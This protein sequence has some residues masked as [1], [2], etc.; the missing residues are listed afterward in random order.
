M[1]STGQRQRQSLTPHFNTPNF[2]DSPSTSITPTTKSWV[3]ALTDLP[4]PLEKKKIINSPKNSKLYQQLFHVRKLLKNK[5]STIA[6]LKKQRVANKNKIISNTHK[7]FNKV[8]FSSKNSRYLV[9]MQILHKKRKPWSENEKK[10][11]MSI[12]YKS[13]STYKHMR[14]IGI[15]LP[16][17]STI[18]R[19]L[20][21]IDYLPG[22][23]GEYIR[24]IKLKVSTMSYTDKKC[25]ILL[26]EMAISK[27]I[28]YN[29]T[30]DLIEGF[31]DLG[32][33]GR[34]SKFAKHA[35]MVMVRGLYNNWKF[36]LC[37]F[38][39]NNGVKGDDLLILIKDCVDNIL[40]VGLL[41]L[42]IVCDQGAQNRKLFS[43]LNGTES[44]P[45]TEIHDQKL[46]LIYDIPHLIKSIRN[47]LLTGDIQL[48]KILITFEDIKKTYKINVCSETAR[49]MCK[50]SP[51]HLNP[52]PFQ[53]MSCKLAL[54]I[55]SNST[56]AAI[57]TCIH[58]GEL[59][60]KTAMDTANFVLEINNTFDACNS[61]NLYD[62]NLNKRPMN[63]N[64]THIFH[65][66]RKT[67]STFQNAKKISHKNKKQSVPP[68]FTG[69]IWSL[70]AII[71]L[72]E[73]EQ[74]DIST[75]TEQD[76]N[77]YFL[78]TNRLNQD[79]LENMFSIIRQK[80]GYTR[81][82][83][84]K[85][86]RSCFA[87][88]CSFSLMK[89]SEKC[90]CEVDEDNFLT[91]DVLGESEVVKNACQSEMNT[92]NLTE[93]NNEVLDK[94][95]QS[96]D[97]SNENCSESE[98]EN[99]KLNVTLEECSISYFAGYLAKRCIDNFQCEN[100]K[101]VLVNNE[102]YNNSNEILIMY[103]T[104]EQIDFF[105]NEGLKKPSTWLIKICK[106]SLNIFKTTFKTIISE[107]RIMTK[108]FDLILIKLN[109]KNIDF[110]ESPCKEHYLYII[111]LLLVI[112]IYKA[113]KWMAAEE[114]VTKPQFNQKHPKLRI[115]Q[116]S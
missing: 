5:R 27:C 80:N 90:N 53:K 1:Y 85:M 74:E 30:I 28:E 100:C 106:I 114:N 101:Q 40:N 76:P 21:S 46:V 54:Q 11:A 24:Q 96:V 42:A 32:S 49:A 7:F 10:I 87:S 9:S 77:K 59:Q 23:V 43:L 93:D 67:I 108:M 25:V 105:G 86:I 17:D 91:L 78:L 41:P 56:S 52:N 99:D 36:P 83:S 63:V 71:S 50:I 81:N 44:N 33:L 12:Y 94:S 16:G 26:D 3:S 39:S 29:K 20:K 79:P 14:K 98:L 35:L 95:F 65:Q 82:P 51:I 70:T 69:I 48:N 110:N 37:Y 18:R 89:A 84:A 111:K 13:P 8:K 31:Q 64:N 6:K 115:L 2:N 68:C 22:F 88:I 34:S 92:T 62:V 72:Y 109:K 103:K 19:W 57:K 15:V 73:S 61:K 60:S 75:N 55:F 107:P 102:I 97:N 4:S 66:L 112:R 113:C 47:N 58:T 104:F 45:I 38:L 116:H